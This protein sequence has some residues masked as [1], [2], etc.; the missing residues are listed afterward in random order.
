[1]PIPLTPSATA[2][3]RDACVSQSSND[4]LEVSHN[5][6]CKAYAWAWNGTSIVTLWIVIST[7]G[8]CD[9][10]TFI[11]ASSGA[12][13]SASNRA[14]EV[15]LTS[16]VR[17]L[18]LKAVKTRGEP[19][20]SVALVSASPYRRKL[21]QRNDKLNAPELRLLGLKETRP[22]LSSSIHMPL[23]SVNRSNEGEAGWNTNSNEVLN[24]AAAEVARN[25]RRAERSMVEGAWHRTRAQSQAGEHSDEQRVQGKRKQ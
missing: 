6:C 17:P 24:L 25:S 10:M 4:G 5:H 14:P 20:A 18:L 22:V 9:I 15:E 8:T 3:D 2:A 19:A 23:C 11:N 1:M 16:N 21:V 13:H 7:L 12:V